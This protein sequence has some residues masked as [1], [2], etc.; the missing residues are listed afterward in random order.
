MKLLGQSGHL[1]LI[2]GS[3][4]SLQGVDCDEEGVQPGL[5]VERAWLIEGSESEAQLEEKESGDDEDLSASTELG[6][7]WNV[8][9]VS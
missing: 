2:D 5:S 1:K 8:P 4:A 7:L 9:E 3:N 6:Q